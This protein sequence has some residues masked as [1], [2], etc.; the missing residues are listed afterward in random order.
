ME[1]RRTLLISATG[2][3]LFS[4]L[5][6]LGLNTHSQS[7][8]GCAVI[9]FVI[10]FSFGLAPVPWV[11]LSEV[12]PQEGRTAVGSVGVGVNWL[13]NLV[14]VSYYIRAS[15]VSLRDVGGMMKSVGGDW[16]TE[17]G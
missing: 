7:L 11:V 6:A 8:A 5:L 12:V 2:T 13:T 17:I 15:K 1:S 16:A 3:T 10:A 14:L 4:L 9:G